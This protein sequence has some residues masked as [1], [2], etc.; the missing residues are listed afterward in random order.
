MGEQGGCSRWGDRLAGEGLSAK[1]APGRLRRAIRSIG[2][3]FFGMTTYEL[4]REARKAQAELHRLFVTLAFGDLVGLPVHPSPITLRLL[5][6]AAPGLP[7]WRRSVSRP[8]DILDLCN[9][10]VS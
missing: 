10:D 6:Y 1:R 7:S 3:F 9:E 5:P 2:Q 4:V 8:R